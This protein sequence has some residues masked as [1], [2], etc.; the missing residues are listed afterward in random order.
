MA[1]FS[2]YFSYFWPY[3]NI[4]SFQKLNVLLVQSSHKTHVQQYN[5]KVR[6]VMCTSTHAIV[7]DKRCENISAETSQ[8]PWMCEN[9]EDCNVLSSFYKYRTI[10]DEISLFNM[11]TKRTKKPTDGQSAKHCGTDSLFLNSFQLLSVEAPSAI[12]YLYVSSNHQNERRDLF[13]F[14]LY[15]NFLTITPKCDMTFR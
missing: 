5:Q 11:S 13:L 15:K 4:F 7:V 8:R 1:K 2:W 6:L 3:E 9:W 10:F 14:I 12:S